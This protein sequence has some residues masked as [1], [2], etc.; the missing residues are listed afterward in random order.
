MDPA[1]STD[2]VAKRLKSM[3]DKYG[4]YKGIQGYN[5][6]GEIGS[7]SLIQYADN[8]L[9]YSGYKPAA[10]INAARKPSSFQGAVTPKNIQNIFNNLGTETTRWGESTR[11]EKFHPGIDIANATGTPITSFTPGIVT[12]TTTGHAHGEKGFGNSVVITDALGNK[13][14]YSH[15]QN[16]NVKPG[17]QV[18]TGTQIGKMGASGSTY[19]PSG[20]GQGTHLD[21]RIVSAANKYLNPNIYLANFYKVV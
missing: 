4:L 10:S 1:F 7:P 6:E 18:T 11:Y 20:K 8:I 14:R 17:Q 15:L 12:S 5:T 13:H 19:S 21:Y 3:V 9:K 16:V 2:W